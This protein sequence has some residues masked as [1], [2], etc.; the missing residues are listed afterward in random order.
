ME[1][2]TKLFGNI[3]IED[4]KIIEF[5]NGMI[6]FPE[7]KK[8]TLIF[9]SENEGTASISWLQSVEKPD[10]AFP[11]ID[12]LVVK[13]DYSPTV[14]DDLIQGLGELTQDNL[15]ILVTM[16]VPSDIEKMTVNLKA[17]L[18]I[19]SDT[20]KGCQIIIEDDLQ[21]RYPVYDILKNAKGDE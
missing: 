8:F 14:E 9:D 11:V 5:E 21:V 18:V 1:I 2:N 13:E 12:P 17:P 6:G 4:K 10:L 19:N 20:R 16:T 3:M 7:Y 15:L